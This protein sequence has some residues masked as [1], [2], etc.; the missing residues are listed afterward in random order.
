MSPSGRVLRVLRRQPRLS[1]GARRQLGERVAADGNHSSLVHRVVHDV[2]RTFAL[3]AASC[4]LEM[5]VVGG[6]D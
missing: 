2:V 3:R 6:D 5:R 4:G 1:D